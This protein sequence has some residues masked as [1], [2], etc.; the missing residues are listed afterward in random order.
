MWKL[1]VLTICL[2]YNYCPD[3]LQ[4]PGAEKEWPKRTTKKHRSTDLYGEADCL[5]HGLTIISRY[6]KE[7]KVKRERIDIECVWTQNINKS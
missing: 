7:R 3:L 4:E 1:A 6:E 5:H 2:G